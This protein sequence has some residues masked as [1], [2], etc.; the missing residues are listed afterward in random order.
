MPVRLTNRQRRFPVDPE[1]LSAQAEACLRHLGMV[2][3]ELSLLLVND[4]AMRTL[5]RDYR[6]VDRPTD[7]LSFP[8]FD[9]PPDRVAAQI[10]TELEMAGEVALG[11]VVISLETAH[12]QAGEWGVP[13]AAELSL[14]LVHGLLHLLGHD[15]ELGPEQAA[16][17]ARAERQLLHNLAINIPGMV[18]RAEAETA[19]SDT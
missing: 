19:G 18:S 3:A 11:D 1:V 5:N 13:A 14:L 17:M 9:G 10:T 4:R 7:V 8:L 2:R 6:A 16:A 15:H 12:R